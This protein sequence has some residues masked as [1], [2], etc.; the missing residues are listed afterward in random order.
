MSLNKNFRAKQA[1]W[2]FPGQPETQMKS[3]HMIKKQT[4]LA[5]LFRALLVSG[6][7]GLLHSVFLVKQNPIITNVLR[8]KFPYLHLIKVT[9]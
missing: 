2:N 9:L 3:C 4:N 8:K 6:E 7:P 1:F 5:T